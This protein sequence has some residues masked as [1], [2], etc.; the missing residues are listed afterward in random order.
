MAM[1]DDPSFLPVYESDAEYNAGILRQ[2]I[3]MMAKHHIPA[4]P[5]NYAIWYEYASGQNHPLKHAVDSLVAK[6]KTFD[7]RISLDLYKSFICN[8]SVS[9]FEKINS[10]LNTLI[11]STTFSV[12]DSS[13]QV[14]EVGDK[15]QQRAIKL[16]E[17]ND[18][19]QVKSVLAGIVSETSQLLTISESLKNEL[20]HAHKEMEQLRGELTKVR[21]MATTDALTGLLNRRAFDS[22]LSEL[23]D[24]Q[25]TDSEHVLMLLD[26]D[27]F[28]KINDTFGHLVGDKVI[29]YTSS[30]LRKNI[31]EHHFAARYGGEEMAVIMPN[32]SVDEAVKIAEAVRGLLAKSQLKQKSSGEK[33][34]KVTVSIGVTVLQA[35]DTPDCFIDRAD[36]ALYQAKQGG[37]NRVVTQ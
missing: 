14:S 12:Q 4:H 16:D 2:S 33:I 35:T 13:K 26:L 30:I 24:L 36:G 1:A 15:V 29:S 5:I 3:P 34:G 37:R 31:A 32:T 11:E 19:S 17:I 9:S 23:F 6:G 20:N 21:E 22:K 8:A 25:T 28:K 10:N 7:D 18:V 27:H